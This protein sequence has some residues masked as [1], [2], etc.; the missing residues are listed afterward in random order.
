MTY[1]IDAAINEFSRV[2]WAMFRV[3]GFFMVVPVI[4]SQLVPPRVRLALTL[5]TAIALAPVIPGLPSA[6][7]LNLGLGIEA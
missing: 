6:D 1:P 5:A 4:G 7:E 3:G 2:I